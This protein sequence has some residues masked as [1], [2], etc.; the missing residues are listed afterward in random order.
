MSTRREFL[1]VSAVGGAVANL[2]H[3]QKVSPNDKIRV[4]CIGMGNMGFGDVKTISTVPGVEFV[5][6]ADI[7]EGRLTNAKERF[8]KQIFTT[9]DYREL[10]ARPDI[11]AVII[12]TPDHWHA[13]QAVDAMKAGKHVYCQKP[14]V[15][16]P[17]DGHKVI[18]A[19][20]STG[21]ILQVGSQRVSSILYSRLREVIKEGKIGEIRMIEAFY[22]RNSALG[23]WQYLIPYDASPT[24][25]DWDRFI[26]A[27]PK[28]PFEPIRLFRW[29]NYRDYGTGIAGDLFVHL[30]S[31]IHYV[32]DS[33][34]PERVFA[35][36]GTYFWNDGRDVPDLMI[37]LYDYAK[38]DKHAAHQITLRVNFEAGTGGGQSFRFVGTEG[39]ITLDV[40]NGF[41]VHST[42]REAR[43]G[44]DLEPFP[45]AVREKFLAE[46]KKKYPDQKPS[47]DA[48]R[49]ATSY[50]YRLPAGY[51][52]QYA[53]HANFIDAIRNNRPVIEDATFGLRAAAPALLSNISY[54][55]KRQV[56]W[57][58][59][60]MKIKA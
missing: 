45:Q 18:A 32:M 26:G 51:T 33:N 15:Q 2:A 29:R 54:F 35:S 57:D 11:D 10:L 37:G 50:S 4:G 5:A 20:K 34:G 31:G 44:F 19:E 59:I 25:V 56:Q 41:T 9:R 16:D 38:T 7:Y 8:G 43:P 6:V 42:P 49:P 52:E 3:A 21:K 12:A 48:M 55:E 46:Y 23:A 47:A 60:A 14:M 24:T 27:A 22:D 36:G 30:F 28:R 58:P 39:Y 53:H 40:G 13:A 1:E 17:A